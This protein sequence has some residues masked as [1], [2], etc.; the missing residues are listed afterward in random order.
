MAGLAH[1]P[2]GGCGQGA[3]DSALWAGG[4]GSPGPQEVLLTLAVWGEGL[5]PGLTAEVPGLQG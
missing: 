2:H 5:K 3:G 4:Q 1:V